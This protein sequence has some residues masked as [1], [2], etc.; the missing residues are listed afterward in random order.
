M[1][2]AY[3]WNQIIVDISGFCNKLHPVDDWNILDIPVS[4]FVFDIE[5][6][7]ESI[8]N[9]DTIQKEGIFKSEIGSFEDTI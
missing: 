4:D 2:L 6:W 5:D 9:S 7:Y 8:R 1:G 3:Y